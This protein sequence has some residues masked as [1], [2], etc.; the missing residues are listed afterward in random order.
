MIPAINIAPTTGVAVNKITSNTNNN[1]SRMG[2]RRSKLMFSIS[3]FFG[4]NKNSSIIFLFVKGWHKKKDRLGM[5]GN[6][7]LN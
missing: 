2:P 6:L 5:G 3:T 7:G 1:T 4:Q